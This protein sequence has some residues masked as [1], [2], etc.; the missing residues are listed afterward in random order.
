MRYLAAI[1]LLLTT[2]VLAQDIHN[3]ATGHDMYRHWIQPGGGVS[4]CSGKDCGPWPEED[5]SPVK[6]GFFIHSLGHFVGMD[7]VLPS[8]DGQYHICCRR[9]RADMPCEL[10]KAGKPA[11][12]CLA[13]PMGY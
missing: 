12:Y 4:C 2:P 10:S 6:D 5:V 7:R 8:P 3:H 9:E 11:V 1:F 13:A